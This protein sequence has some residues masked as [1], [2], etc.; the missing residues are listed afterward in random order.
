MI[1]IAALAFAAAGLLTA[2]G[3]GAAQMNGGSFRALI[4]ALNADDRAAVQVHLAE[5]FQL[6]FTGGTTVSGDD[7]VQILMLLDTPIDIVSVTPGGD[8]K[9][10]AVLTFGN[11]TEHYTVDY[12]GARGGKVATITI[13]APSEGSSGD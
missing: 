13:S 11:T 7:A 5:T 2:V 4:A 10:T 3:D 6:T 1:A 8:Q 12:T 9:G